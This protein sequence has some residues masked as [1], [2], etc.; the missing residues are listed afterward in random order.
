[1][2]NEQ[3]NSG[4]GSPVILAGDVPSPKDPQK[5]H[6]VGMLVAAFLLIAEM[7]GSG[8]FALPKALSNTGIAL[9]NVIIFV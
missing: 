5:D 7:A 3:K 9:F 1:M 8:V 6:S 4:N 2:T